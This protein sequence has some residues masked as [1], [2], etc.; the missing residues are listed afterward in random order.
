[1]GENPDVRLPYGYRG[2]G[3][4]RHLGLDYCAD[5]IVYVAGLS[6]S[7]SSYAAFVTCFDEVMKWKLRSTGAI[8]FFGTDFGS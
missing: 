8:C 7:F 3:T 4:I 6:K 2:N 1:M 5:R